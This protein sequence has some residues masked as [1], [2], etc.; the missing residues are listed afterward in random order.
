[1]DKTNVVK[2][3]Y[4][5]PWIA[6]RADPYVYKAKDGFYYF[7]ASVPE[8]DRIVLRR[9]KRL[10][11]LACAEEA[12]IWKR[13]DSG[14]MSEHI[15]APEIHYLDDKWYIYF[16]AG[17]KEDKWKIRPYV[18]ECQ[19][20]DPMT[21]EW[22][23]KG[24]MQSCDGDDLSFTSFSLDATVFEHRGKRYLVWAEK[25]HLKELVSNL[26]I[27]EMESPIKLKTK[28]VLLTTPEYDWEIVEFYVNE[29]PAILKKNNKIFLTYSASSTGAC[30][31]VGMLVADEDADLLDPGSW[32]KMK[33]PVLRTDESKA[34]YGPGHNSFTVSEDGKEIMVFHARQ[35][36]QIVG[37]P[38][39]DPNRHTMFLE[40]KWNKDGMP[41]FEYMSNEA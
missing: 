34:V 23:E 10:K 13:H 16:A 31:C 28:R 38:L 41:E 11:D 9:S 2:T 21:G 30:Y 32:T 37:D 8:Y 1:M 29:G 40:I 7:T 14:I 20:K 19:G 36:S 4:N 26:Y 17:E 35:Y 3:K 33:E 24:R 15:W 5:T 25:V 18:L 12:V 22:I 6:N 39:Y 27:A